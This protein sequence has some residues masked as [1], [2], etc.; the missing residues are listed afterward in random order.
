MR[1]WRDLPPERRHLC[2]Q[3]LR[4][5]VVGLGVTMVQ[6]AVYWLLAAR[7]GVHSQIANLMGYIVAVMLGYVLHG[8]FSFVDPE[9]EGGAAAHAARGARFVA[10]SLVSLALNA[11]WVWLSVS[12]MRWPEWAPI[13]AMIFVTPGIVFVLNRHWVFR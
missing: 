4:Y 11:L 12:W 9:R 1:L 3:I 13:P 2:V 8:R 7:A 10:V 6:A 5:G